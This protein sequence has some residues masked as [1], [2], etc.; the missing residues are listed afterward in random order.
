MWPLDTDAVDRQMEWIESNAEV[1]RTVETALG[2][3]PSVSSLHPHIAASLKAHGKG[4]PRHSK[5]IR[6]LSRREYKNRW[7]AVLHGYRDE[8]GR[9]TR[10]VLR[11]WRRRRAIG[12][13]EEFEHTNERLAEP[14]PWR[15][16]EYRHY[17]QLWSKRYK[18]EYS[19]FKDGMPV[20]SETE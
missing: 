10:E 17:A 2:T 12:S 1:D 6:W 5:K 4:S 11:P 7:S 19:S 9:R 3:A 13:Y 20:F 15:S 8:Y 14:Q 16:R 18:H